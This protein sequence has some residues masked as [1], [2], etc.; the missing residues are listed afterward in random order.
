MLAIARG[1][2]MRP[3]VLL[4]DE[5]SQGLA[6]AIVDSLFDLVRSLPEQGVS[7]LIV[8][9][10]VTHALGVATR[11]Y[12]L[13]KGEVAYAGS[14]AEL[15]EDEEF[16]RGSY[17]GDATADPDDLADLRAE[18]TPDELLQAIEKRAAA[19][20]R[21][22][23][24]VVMGLLREAMKNRQRRRTAT[25]AS[26]EC[27]GQLTIGIAPG[28]RARL[29]ALVLVVAPAS[30]S[31]P[32][33]GA[34]RRHQ[35]D[36][37]RRHRPRDRREHGVPELHERRRRQL[38]LPRPLPHRQL[39]VRGG[40][41]EPGRHRPARPDRAPRRRATSSRST[42]TPAGPARSRASTASFGS[43]GGPSAYATAG[44]YKATALSSE[45]S[46]SGAPAEPMKIAVPKGFDRRLRLA[47]AA[48]KARWL[49]RRSTRSNLSWPRGRLLPAHRARADRARADGADA[50]R[51][52]RDRP[53]A[54]A[55]R[56]PRLTTTTSS[57]TT[58]PTPSK[59]AGRTAGSSRRAS[60]R[61]I[62]RAAPSSPPESRA[63]GRRRS[64]RGQIVLKHV[65]VTVKI[66]NSGTPKGTASVS[67]GGATVGGVPVTIDQNGVH[68]QGQ[69]SGLP[70][71]QADDALNAALKTAG[72]QMYTVDPQTKKSANEMTITRP[73]S[74]STSRSRSTSPAFPR[75][76]CEHIVGEVF[77]D[78]LAAPATPL[79]KLSSRRDGLEPRRRRWD[80]RPASRAAAGRR[81]VPRRPAPR[82]RLRLRHG[83]VDRQR[84]RSVRLHDVART[85]RCGSSSPTSS[86]RRS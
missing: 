20:G 11:A 3:R 34:L 70:Y 38:L 6:P 43:A 57:T 77:A 44:N 49:G 81:R 60:P 24:E 10:F 80:A 22:P 62:R 16:V 82:L 51:A 13:E 47:L 66:T 50:D 5:M 59:N 28:E 36:R 55:A 25:E 23:G 84:D 30:A 27:A 37:E 48:W 9:Q 79:P 7:V 64:A 52:R 63:S 2:I 21:D 72:V 15:M 4:I 68:V 31:S 18:E 74:T 67:V 54:A 33:S 29:S 69:G 61:S 86:G 73:A 76:P 78:S 19:E 1:L 42:P 40:H 58:T 35:R 41:R 45:A 17:L 14:A 8:E 39:A 56:R 85:S 12:V 26:H 46:G 75:R 83:L 65:D 32:A 53:D 71:G